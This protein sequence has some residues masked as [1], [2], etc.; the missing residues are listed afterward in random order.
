MT[1][2]ASAS[3]CP[4]RRISR[5]AESR[6]ARF[7]NTAKVTAIN[8]LPASRR[9]A[10]LVA[11]VAFALCLEATAYDDALDVLEALLRDLFSNAERADKKARLRS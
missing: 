9:M 1:C 5:P 10:A 3:P 11:L 7:A 2:V 6:L 4:Q 8:R